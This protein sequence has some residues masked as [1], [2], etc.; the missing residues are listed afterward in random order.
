MTTDRVA[1]VIVVGRHSLAGTIEHRGSRVLDVLNDT[2]TEFLRVHEVAVFR[3]LKGGPLAEY[4]EITVPKSAIDCALLA[5]NRH[6][7]PLRRQY[8]RVE[9]HMHCMFALVTDHEIRGRA[10]FER[11]ADTMSILNSGASNFF[12]VVNVSVLSADSNGPPMSAAVAFVNKAKV[13][14][15]HVEQKAAVQT[16]AS[17]SPAEKS[18][19][20]T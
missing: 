11:S 15:L 20:T 9:K 10:M 3:G 16:E 6:E 2:S 14:L 4:A 19:G 8:A 12:P 18:V 17:S 1:V 13:L 7:A 5:D